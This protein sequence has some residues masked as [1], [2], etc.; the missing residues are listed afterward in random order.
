MAPPRVTEWLHGERDSLSGMVL[1]LEG[2]LVSLTLLPSTGPGSS[3][4]VSVPEAWFSLWL[5]WPSS[6]RS[7]MS[8]NGWL[9]VTQQK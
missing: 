9:I 7:P 6:Q 4:D 2:M 5:E 3:K 1:G 8:L